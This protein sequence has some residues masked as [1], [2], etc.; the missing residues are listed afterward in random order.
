MAESA[1][2]PRSSTDEGLREF[3]RRT[4]PRL[5][6]PDHL[7]PIFDAYDKVRLAIR[8]EGPP[9]FAAFSIPPQ[10]GKTT[11]HLTALTWLIATADAYVGYLTYNQ[12]KANRE[13]KKSRDWIRLASVDLEQDTTAKREWRTPEGGGMLAGGLGGGITG[14]D[15]LS[16]I[17]IDDPHKNREEAESAVIREKV[18]DAFEDDIWSRLHD[19]TSLIVN[20][21]RWHPEDLI[22]RVMD[23]M[24][25]KFVYV[26]FPA[27]LPSGE[28]LWPEKHSLERLLY[29]R[30]KR[31]DYKWASLYMGQPILR[32]SRLFKDNPPRYRELPSH[33]VRGIGVDLAYTESSRADW[34][35]A[36]AIG[37]NGPLRYVL[38]VERAQCEMDAFAPRLGRM[39]ER[40][41]KCPIVFRGAGQEVEIARSLQRL[42]HQLG[43]AATVIFRQTRNDKFVNAQDAHADW[44]ANKILLPEA[45]PWLKPATEEG[46]FRV[47]T[48]FTGVGDAFDD[49]VDSLVSAHLA[50][51]DE[52]PPNAGAALPQPDISR[53][54]KRRRAAW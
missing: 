17:V 11:L 38:D 15:A 10:H 22:G 30:E 19:H 29:T 39:W 54:W 40:H 23:V 27:I 46:W 53:T 33:L 36:T 9:V 34:S 48:R 43:F 51:G 47:V 12:T 14:Y 44:K 6:Q 1:P 24:G 20:H 2:R 35:V 45:A 28:A 26:N 49:D 18:W 16:C 3:F 25:D 42:L 32:G 21:T 50:V 41:G 52:P 4:H 5:L 31:G 37:R 7:A 13:S 8:G